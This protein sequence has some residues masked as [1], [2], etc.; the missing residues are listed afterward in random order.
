M[1]ALDRGR[2]TPK[3][4]ARVRYRVSTASPPADVCRPLSARARQHLHIAET[5]QGDLT[6]DVRRCQWLATPR[7]DSIGNANERTAGIRVS[8]IHRNTIPRA[9][10]ARD[11]SPTRR[12]ELSIAMS[13]ND[14]DRRIN[15]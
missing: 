15:P 5:R 12:K 9:G 1:G 7:S 10:P 14:V 8:V 3:S 11:T 4:Q 2:S 13:I 6:E